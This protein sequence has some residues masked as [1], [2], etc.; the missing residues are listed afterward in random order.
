M[1]LGDS[2]RQSEQCVVDFLLVALDSVEV[3]D[4]LESEVPCRNDTL[5]EHT[6]CTYVEGEFDNG[7]VDV[8]STFGVSYESGASFFEEAKEWGVRVELV[9]GCVAHD[10][11]DVIDVLCRIGDAKI[12]VTFPNFQIYFL[13]Y[14]VVS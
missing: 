13:N 12:R 3:L 5:A 9:S 2:L 7:S 4:V 11:R 6:H 10:V 8:L 1:T 14:V